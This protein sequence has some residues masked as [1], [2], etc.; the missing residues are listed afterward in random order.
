MDALVQPTTYTLDDYDLTLS[1]F[2]QTVSR[3]A[4]AEG[5][6]KFAGAVC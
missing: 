4:W 5:L 1:A 3:S 6:G 2:G